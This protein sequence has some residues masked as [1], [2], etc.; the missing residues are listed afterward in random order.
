[1]S[2]T[3]T[4]KKRVKDPIRECKRVLDELALNAP[5]DVVKTLFPVESG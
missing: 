1:M 2:V 4:L 3:Q 5:L